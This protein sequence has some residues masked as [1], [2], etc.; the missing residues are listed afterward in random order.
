M[1]LTI[2]SWADKEPSIWYDMWDTIGTGHNNA[3][4]IEACSRRYRE[5]DNIRS[6]VES[7][8]EEARR[9]ILDLLE[10]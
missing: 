10:K 2:Y 9:L 7:E 1:K 4:L 6:N 5:I 3:L 8:R